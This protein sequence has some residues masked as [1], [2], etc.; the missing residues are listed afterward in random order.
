MKKIKII[1]N[2]MCVLLALCAC[3]SCSAD[4]TDKETDGNGTTTQDTVNTGV[5]TDKASNGEVQNGDERVIYYSGMLGDDVS[6]SALT[7]AKTTFR[8]LDGRFNESGTE[9]KKDSK[10]STKK[11]ITIGQQTYSLDYNQSVDNAFM[12][13]GYDEYVGGAKVKISDKDDLLVDFFDINMV[14][15]P[16]DQITETEE[17]ARAKADAILLELYG[18]E[19]KAK[20]QYDGMAEDG[21]GNPMYHFIY[22][23]YAWGYRTSDYIGIS[24]NANGN[25]SSIDTPMFAA[26]YNAE[27]LFSKEDVE[28]TMAIVEDSVP[29]GYDKAFVEL[30][31]DTS[32]KFYVRYI[33]AQRASENNPNWMT[34]IYSEIIPSNA[35]ND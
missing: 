25:C 26:A 10:I 34:S 2:I 18:E 21:S 14:S 35:S 17:S 7:N 5:E 16:G 28:A 8:I 32:G 13:R 20:Y 6:A 31:M 19:A 27:Q 3:T 22:R 29:D 9:I 24:I 15:E 33:M 23:V 4:T 12:D 1:T 11:S 30:S